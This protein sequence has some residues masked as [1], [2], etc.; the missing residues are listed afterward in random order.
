MPETTPF[1]AYDPM[2]RAAIQLALGVLG[3]LVAILTA[4]I[5]TRRDMAVA[6]I[7][8]VTLAL[9][10]PDAIMAVTGAED[11]RLVYALAFLCAA[12]GK[13]L[14]IQVARRPVDFIERLLSRL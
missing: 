11:V 13:S 1:P 4:D 5:V 12:S 2:G 3:S 7:S 9:V 8:G 6:L 10:A 14:M